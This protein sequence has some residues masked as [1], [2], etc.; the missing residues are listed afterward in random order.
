MGE[1]QLFPPG[2]VPECTTAEWYLTRARAP[3]LEEP[4]Q[5]ERLLTTADLAN[6]LIADFAVSTVSD[7]GCGD[8]GLLSLLKGMASWGYDISPAAVEGAHQRGVKASLLDVIHSDDTQLWWGELSVCTEMLEHQ[9]D[10]HGFLRRVGQHS[11]YVIASSPYT[12]TGLR[13][14]EFH[15]WAWDLQGYRK[16]FEDA[17]W[18][19]LRQQTVQ[20][21]QVI[22]AMRAGGRR[23]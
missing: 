15:T 2:T 12:E 19:V 13:H 3:H 1:W 14:Y 21:F 10:P 5:R 6:R 18:Q 20:S 8:G 23:S 16:M 17:G 11:G 7:L 22:A 9:V 4:G